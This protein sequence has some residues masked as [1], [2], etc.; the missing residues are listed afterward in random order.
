[1]FRS[2]LAPWLCTLTV[3]TA[4]AQTPPIVGEATQEGDAVIAASK[5]MSLVLL[6]SAAEPT[7]VAFAFR[8]SPA[9]T[10]GVTGVVLSIGATE[11]TRWRDPSL[12][13]IILSRRGG[14]FDGQYLTAA[15]SGFNAGENKMVN[16]RR[17]HLIFWP[18][19]AAERKAMVDDGVAEQSWHGRWLSGRIDV[20]AGHVTAYLDGRLMHR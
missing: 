1:M 6:E 13:Q 2:C 12:G 7:R 3:S 9:S 14:E 8:M 4:L 20:A 19:R 18:I 5:Q 15:M 16:I 17:E 10:P 11:P